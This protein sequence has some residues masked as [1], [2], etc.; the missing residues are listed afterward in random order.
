MKFEVEVEWYTTHLS[1]C[2]HRFSG[3]VCYGRFSSRARTISVDSRDKKS[4]TVFF[5]C[6]LFVA[7]ELF[8]TEANSWEIHYLNLK[9][10]YF[11]TSKLIV[12]LIFGMKKFRIIFIF[13]FIKL[14]RVVPKI[15]SNDFGSIWDNS[16]E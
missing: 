8:C 11:F 5:Y 16:R 3:R 7:P 2:L 15:I 12:E 10:A 6:F 1:K 14:F 13:V 4:K 9:K